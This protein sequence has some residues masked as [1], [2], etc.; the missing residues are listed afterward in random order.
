[1]FLTV[2]LISISW[3]VQ[4]ETAEITADKI[5]T[6]FITDFSGDSPVPLIYEVWYRRYCRMEKPAYEKIMLPKFLYPAGIQ[7]ENLL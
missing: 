6:K 2:P 5:I 3:A 7:D 4:N 1:M